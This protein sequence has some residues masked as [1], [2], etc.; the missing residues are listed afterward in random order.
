[1]SLPALNPIDNTSPSPDGKPLA[2]IES[3]LDVLLTALLKERERQRKTPQSKPIELRVISCADLDAIP[4]LSDQEV[5]QERIIERPVAG[6][7][8]LAIHEIGEALFKKGG[9]DLM[10]DSLE[11]VASR[12]RKTYGKRI[13]ICDVQRMAS[14][15]SGGTSVLLASEDSQIGIR[16]RVCLYGQD[17]THPSPS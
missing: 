12:R 13:S 15:R 9:T 4:V 1:M 11:R 2:E 14:A 16:M 7:L 17:G 8:E 10:R 3:A 5:W 6:A